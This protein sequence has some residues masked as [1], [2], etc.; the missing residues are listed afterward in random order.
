MRI[1]WGSGDPSGERLITTRGGCTA[2][3]RRRAFSARREAAPR[4]T[5]AG[6]TSA[7][8]LCAVAR[9]RRFVRAS[10]SFA[11]P[12]SDAPDHPASNG[13]AA[14]GQAPPARS[15]GIEGANPNERCRLQTAGAWVRASPWRTS[16]AA[17][18][19]R[20][21]LYA[22]RSAAIQRLPALARERHEEPHP[23]RDE[24]RGMPPRMR[25]AWRS[26]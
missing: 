1:G 9:I 7:R 18:P 6:S 2:S 21:R 12:P 3:R 16:R 19:M 26:I 13:R 11:V 24:R 23:C 17:C 4:S 15:P 20:A 25:V 5:R 22:R 14:G 10:M 8:F